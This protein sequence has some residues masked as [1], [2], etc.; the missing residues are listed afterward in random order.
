MKSLKA[1]YPAIMPFAPGVPIITAENWIRQAAIEFCERTKLWRWSDSFTLTSDLSEDILSPAGS[2]VFGIELAELDGR[3]LT[4]VTPEWLDANLSGWRTNENIEGGGRYFTQLEPNTICV[5]PN[6]IGTLYL[7]LFLKP[8][9]DATE[10]PDFIADQYRQA[11]ADGALGQILAIPN[12]SFTDTQMAIAR[13][14]LFQSRLDSLANSGSTGQQRARVG[15]K[16][17]FM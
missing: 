15:T 10:V 5:V 1:F 14:Q 13:T 11:I 3:K 8:S 16:P 6:S 12:Q 4:S 7:S 17:R 9:H 2:T